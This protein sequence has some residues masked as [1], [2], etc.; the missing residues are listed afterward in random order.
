M[1]IVRRVTVATLTLFLS[2]IAVVGTS[3]TAHADDAFQYW[4]YWQL[5]DKGTF[6]YA[7]K[8]AAD[9]KP[10]DGSVEG[11]RWSATPMGSTNVP[12]ADLTKV[13]FETICA[14]EEATDGQ[15]RV[16]VIVDFG[17]EAD[18][19]G[20][21]ET[22]EPFAA[23]AVVPEDA[24]G[25]QVLDAVADVRTKQTSGGTLLCGID[26]Y[27]STTCADSMTPNSTPEDQTV[28][29]EIRGA[30]VGAEG[31]SE[32]EDEGDNLPLLIGAGVVVVA[33][34]AGGVALARRG[35]SAA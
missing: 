10:A 33:L 23:C 5:T 28:D 19:I 24:T 17:L 29:V 27:P 21:D 8:G 35:R 14:G 20:D 1:H 15:K 2:G 34:G 3:G 6:D 13:N 16:A 26:G 31:N 32:N 7:P 11:H 30:G 22:P 4:S 18:A 12:R 9:T 25:L